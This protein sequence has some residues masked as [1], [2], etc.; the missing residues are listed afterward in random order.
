M[1]YDQGVIKNEFCNKVP[2]E[3]TTSPTTHIE[4]R[5]PKGKPTRKGWGG[6][7]AGRHPAGVKKP[8]PD[9]IGPDNDGGTAFEDD[10]KGGSSGPCLT[11]I[12]L[13][14]SMSSRS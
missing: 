6:I 8:A 11:G 4:S 13:T 5:P 14:G 7:G 12:G 9:A 2:Q 10:A 3:Q 1:H